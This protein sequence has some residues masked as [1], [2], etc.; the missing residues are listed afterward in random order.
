MWCFETTDKFTKSDCKSVSLPLA[1]RF[2]HSSEQCPKSKE[3]F[4][5][6]AKVS[7]FNAI[8]SI[9]YLTICFRL[10]L[11]SRCMFNPREA[12]WEAMKWLSR[13]IK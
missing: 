12:H 10:D 1:N 5:R 4:R 3:E 2:K 8:R 6:M 7:Y 11:L 13:Y 9:M